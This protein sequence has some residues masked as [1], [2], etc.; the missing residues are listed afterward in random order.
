MLN[1]GLGFGRSLVVLSST[2]FFVPEEEFTAGITVGT[3]VDWSRRPPLDRNGSA[4]G[5]LTFTAF[6]RT[7][8]LHIKYRRWK[9]SCSVGRAN[10]SDI[11]DLAY[12]NRWVSNRG[13]QLP[14]VGNRRQ[15][16]YV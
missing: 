2:C 7:I 15:Q 1:C 11:Y 16:P 12:R 9:S 8:F 13:L 14:T 10:V 4:L 3:G 6:I 5:A